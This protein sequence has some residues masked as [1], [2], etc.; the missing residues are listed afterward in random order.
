MV[1]ADAMHTLLCLARKQFGADAGAALQDFDLSSAT[2]LE[3][4]NLFLPQSA[5]FS[6]PYWGFATRGVI[7]RDGK[8]AVPLK[9]RIREADRIVE[10]EFPAGMGTGTRSSLTYLVPPGVF[11]HFEVWAGLQP[12]TRHL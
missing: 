12:M 1:V 4:K 2:P 3:A 10:K 6:K 5:F 9:L 8:E 7:L 11:H